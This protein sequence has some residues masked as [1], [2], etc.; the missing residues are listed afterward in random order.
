MGMCGMIWDGIWDTGWDETRWDGK[1]WGDMG[2][3]AMGCDGEKQWRRVGG[4]LPAWYSSRGINAGMR[5][6]PAQH[7]K[8]KVYPYMK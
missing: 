7:K 2:W 1:A 6:N 4:H 8:A 5:R 3:D